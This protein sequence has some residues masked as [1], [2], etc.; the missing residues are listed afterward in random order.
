M[1]PTSYARRFGMVS[2]RGFTV[3]QVPSLEDK[4]AVIT[5]GQSGIG[6]EVSTLL[7]LNNIGKIYI[8]ARTIS[9][10]EDA[11]RDWVE[12]RGLGKDSIDTRTEFIQCDLSDITSVK[13][14]ASDLLRKLDRLD[15]LFNNAGE[16][17]NN[18]IWH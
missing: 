5:G 4:V 9:K 15:V 16:Y 18:G 2:T 6:R 8:L 13:Q 11:K 10:Y 14:V 3:D 17:E 12:Q 1:T 7:L